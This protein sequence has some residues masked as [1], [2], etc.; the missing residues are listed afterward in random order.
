MIF[1]GFDQ[2][3][4]DIVA[5]AC[6]SFD[7]KKF[8]ILDFVKRGLG[9]RDLSKIEVRGEVIEK[10]KMKVVPPRGYMSS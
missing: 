4:T 1:A 9:T 2:V 7:P 5:V 10:V 3:A 6:M 8:E